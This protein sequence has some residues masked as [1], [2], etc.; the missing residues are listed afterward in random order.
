M[1]KNLLRPKQ[2]KPQQATLFDEPYFS[3]L[4]KIEYDRLSIEN[5]VYLDFTGGNLSAKSQIAS[6]HQLLNRSVFGNPHST[7][8]SS[9]EA[10]TA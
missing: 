8:P 10:L 4:R 1:L 5:H 6:H 7:N 2:S 9:K 3:E